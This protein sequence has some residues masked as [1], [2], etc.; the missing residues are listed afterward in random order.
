MPCL[1]HQDAGPDAVEEREISCY[2][3]EFN[4]DSSI[5][6]PKPIPVTDSAISPAAGGSVE[7]IPE[8]ASEAS[9]MVDEQRQKNVIM[10]YHCCIRKKLHKI[11]VLC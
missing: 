5:F 1:H 2:L 6:Y 7:Y 11:C 8:T 3:R 4:P 9:C 10:P